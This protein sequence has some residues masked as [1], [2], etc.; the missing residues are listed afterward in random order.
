MNQQYT[1]KNLKDKTEK[2]IYISS[3]NNKGDFVFI[4]LKE[5]YNI[6]LIINKCGYDNV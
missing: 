5:L 3:L 2:K 6:E 1:Q 4:D